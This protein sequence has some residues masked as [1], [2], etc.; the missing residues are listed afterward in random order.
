MAASAQGT[1]AERAELMR[2]VALR[3][4]RGVVTVSAEGG[5]DSNVTYAPDNNP[6]CT[7]PPCGP[8]ADGSGAAGIGISLRP[9]GL[10]GPYLRGGAFYRKQ[11]QTSSEDL[12]DF[13]GQVGWRI[14]RGENYAF[15][16]YGYEALLLGG[17]PYLLAHRL[18]AGGRWRLGRTALSMVYAARFGS[19]QTTST[20]NFSGLLQSADPGVTILFGLASSVY[21]GAHLARDATNTADTSSWAAGPRAAV[22]IAITP[23]FRAR[24]EVDFTSRG[25]DAAPT[26]CTAS[27]NARDDKSTW[28]GGAVEK[29]FERFTVSAA[30][31]YQINSSNTDGYSYRRFT[32]SLGVS[33]ALGLF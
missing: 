18:R 25:F 23:T 17:S 27:C 30:A 21:L 28:F 32:A 1:L 13:S 12:G 19:W 14:G 20:S 9:L 29:D 24:G 5:Y 6:S 11:G 3:G 26:T 10:S 22:R 16:D 31:G 15:G 8:L 2:A 7:A 33:Y 4:G